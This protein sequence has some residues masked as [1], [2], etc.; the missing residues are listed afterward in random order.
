[1]GDTDAVS[2][3]DKTEVEVKVEDSTDEVVNTAQGTEE[4]TS[5][6]DSSK[7]ESSD[8]KRSAG[9]VIANLGNE[10]KSIASKFVSLAR[11]SET[12]RQQVKDMLLED[13][14]TANY[15]KTKFGDDYDFIVG[16]KTVEDKSVDV[17]KIREEE[18]VKAEAKAIKESL[19]LNTEQTLQ[20]KAKE[21]GFTT[22]EYERFKSK[23]NI[24]GG[25]EDA[26]RD[27]ALIV[28]QKKAAA[29]TGDYV[30]DGGEAEKPL[31]KEVTITTGLSDYSD[32]QHLDKKE[33][34]TDIDR[35]K[36]L[37]KKDQFGKPV[38]ELPG[39]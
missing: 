17:E 25:D 27:A 12:S 22:E 31:K 6:N 16:E 29:N 30:P 4:E 28:N 32:S 11:S 1:M 2:T 36:G 5:T 33:F 38:M 39:L 14:S 8:D 20:A 7:Q 18:R 21:Y 15:L 37:H 19:E 13:P 3:D 35:V 9:Q 26:I 10:K 24:L 34:A 23:V